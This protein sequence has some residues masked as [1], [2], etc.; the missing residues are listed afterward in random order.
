MYAY[1]V[2]IV[3]NIMAFIRCFLCFLFCFIWQI[4]VVIKF[5][6]NTN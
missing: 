5:K 1:M 3:A 6:K 2:T 4:K